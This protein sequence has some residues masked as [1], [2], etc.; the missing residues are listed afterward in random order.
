MTWAITAGII[1]TMAGGTLAVRP[2]GRAAAIALAVLSVG[3]GLHLTLVG[4]AIPAAM[5]ATAGIASAAVLGLP[6]W[7]KEKEKAPRNST[8]EHD[9]IPTFFRVVAIATSAVVAY[10]L[11][12]TLPLRPLAAAGE[13]SFAWY[14][15]LVIALIV[16][17]LG[18]DLPATSYGLVT[19]SLTGPAFFVLLSS[20]GRLEL[21]L[22]G[23]MG[24]IVLALVLVRLRMAMPTRPRPDPK[25]EQPPW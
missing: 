25:S 17:L 21:S 20:E 4:Q 14:W 12:H 19:L 10:G 23:S 9:Q 6:D 16:L 22:V 3:W 2:S 18:R 11:S 7:I 5:Q 15:L 24:T 13:V 1:V 8:N